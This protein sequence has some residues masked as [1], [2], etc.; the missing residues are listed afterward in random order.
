[1]AS[2]TRAHKS[3]A[4]WLRLPSRSRYMLRH[5]SFLGT[6]GNDIGSGVG[7]AGG[8]KHDDVRYT[9][10]INLGCQALAVTGPR[11]VRLVGLVLS[12]IEP[13]ET[14]SRPLSTVITS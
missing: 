5:R 10:G 12:L 9:H 8:P 6:F 3:S 2:C 14:G 13:S 4:L 1:M 11:R 7:L